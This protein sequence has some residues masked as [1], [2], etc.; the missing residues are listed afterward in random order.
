MPRPVI[1]EE[2]GNT[3]VLPSGSAPDGSLPRVPPELQDT[4]IRHSNR[5]NIPRCHFEIKGNDFLCAA[6][7]EDELT[8]FVEAIA[9]KAKDEWMAVMLEEMN[10]MA[11]NN[12]WELVDLP[13]G[14][15]MVQLRSIRHVI[16]RKVILN[17]KE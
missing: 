15:K 17:E 8:S 14:R 10:S 7:D 2:D 3:S 4:P 12:V 9:S 11:K 16:W 1:D 6:I 13:P 5:G